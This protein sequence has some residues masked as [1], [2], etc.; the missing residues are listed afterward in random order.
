MNEVELWIYF[1]GPEPAHIK[2]LLDSMRELPP[3]SHEDKER[4]GQGVMNRIDE[5]ISRRAE[6]SASGK[7]SA[8]RAPIAEGEPISDDTPRSAPDTGRIFSEGGPTARSPSFDEY[9]HAWPSPAP[10]PRRASVEVRAASTPESLKITEPVL[11]LPPAIRA[12]MGRLPIKP[13]PPAPPAPASPPAPEERLDTTTMVVPVMRP[14]GAETSPLGDSSV[15][16]A[17]AVL[18]FV[19]NTVGMGLV[20]F[21]RLTIEQYASFR[22][23][24]SLWPK[25]SAQIHPRYHV[26]NNAARAALDEHWKSH[27]E[28]RPKAR[29]RF[30]AAFAEYRAWVGGAGPK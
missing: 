13:A 14:I 29:A 28:E 26:A 7:R 12:Q 3:L 2:P 18:P 8:Q 20:A 30:E 4:L 16:R 6:S 10:K 9:I 5:A 23:D 27:F 17:M 24:L 25:R 19:G 15:Q 21:P 11:E 22:V 1:A